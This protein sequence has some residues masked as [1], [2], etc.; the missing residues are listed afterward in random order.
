[1]RQVI[2]DPSVHNSAGDFAAESTVQYK[3]N[4]SPWKITFYPVEKINPD[5][6]SLCYSRKR[7]VYKDQW[8]GWMYKSELSEAGLFYPMTVEEKEQYDASVGVPQLNCDRNSSNMS[9]ASRYSSIM[10]ES[11]ASDIEMNEDHPHL[12]SLDTD[13]E[14]SDVMNEMTKFPLAD[15]NLTVLRAEPEGGNTTKMILKDVRTGDQLYEII[16]ARPMPSDK[17]GLLKK[18][19]PMLEIWG[20][21]THDGKD[22]EKV[23]PMRLL[24]L[25]KKAF[26]N[27]KI[28]NEAK[29][30]F[31]CKAYS[32][33]EACMAYPV[34][35]MGNTKVDNQEGQK[36]NITGC[37]KQLFKEVDSPKYMKFYMEK[38][39]NLSLTGVYHVIDLKSKERLFKKLNVI[40][41]VVEKPCVG[42]SDAYVSPR[43]NSFRN[44]PHKVGRRSRSNSRN[45]NNGRRAAS[46]RRA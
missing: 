9:Y 33:F 11:D 34:E 23:V 20:C 44:R 4:Q 19:Q 14:S 25:I 40:P 38:W 28:K 2:C 27:N 39:K 17:R 45:R 5:F 18:K 7:V 22:N 6:L 35:T 3:Q 31:E 42:D 12:P 43:K 10:S 37:I 30:R 21:P 32:T 29:K 46:G 36:W 8:P 24:S 1:M 13:D 26:D 16:P 15:R 41:H